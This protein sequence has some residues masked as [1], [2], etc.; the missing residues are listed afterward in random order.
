M[1]TDRLRRPPRARH[2]C[3]S[4]FSPR[5]VAQ[6]KVASEKDRLRLCPPAFIKG[7]TRGF[8]RPAPVP[9]SPPLWRRAALPAVC[10]PSTRRG[11]PSRALLGLGHWTEGRHVELPRVQRTPVIRKTLVRTADARIRRRGSLSSDGGKF[12]QPPARER[13]R[14]DAEDV[15]TLRAPEGQGAVLH[16][17]ALVRPITVIE[18]YTVKFE[19]SDP[20][21]S[22]ISTS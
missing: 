16:E 4:P 6:E 11:R 18:K 13:P 20:D 22:S 19:L 7:W 1:K 17:G 3:A 9:P 2:A 21:P 15:K 5:C 10:A 14:D 12:P 8:P